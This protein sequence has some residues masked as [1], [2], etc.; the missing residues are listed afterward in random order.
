MSTPAPAEIETPSAEQQIADIMECFEFE[1]MQLV[2]AVLAL[3]WAGLDAQG[4]PDIF[5]PTVRELRATA[6]RLLEELAA[7]AGDDGIRITLGFFARKQ[8]GY[9]ALY[10]IPC[11]W[12]VLP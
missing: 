5:L 2:M 9:F 7:E 1:R 4:E 6:Q 10:F 11:S 12:E 8:A 3:G